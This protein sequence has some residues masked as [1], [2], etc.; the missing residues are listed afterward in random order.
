MFLIDLYNVF[1]IHLYC[2]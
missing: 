1:V 2:S